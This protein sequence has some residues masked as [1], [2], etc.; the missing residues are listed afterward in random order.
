MTNSS[1][2]CLIK[3]KTDP[4]IMRSAVIKKPVLGVKTLGR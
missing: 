2:D 1:Y 3:K 4:I